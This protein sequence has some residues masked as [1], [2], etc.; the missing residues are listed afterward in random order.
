LLAFAVARGKLPDQMSNESLLFAPA[1]FPF[2]PIS[3]IRYREQVAPKRPVALAPAV[4]PT[5]LPEIPV[6]CR[7]EN[8]KQQYHVPLQLSAFTFSAYRGSEDRRGLPFSPGTRVRRTQIARSSARPSTRWPLDAGTP[9]R[10]TNMT[11]SLSRHGRNEAALAAVSQTNSL[12]DLPY[13]VLKGRPSR[14][15]LAHSL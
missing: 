11:A 10:C 1:N 12:Q 4:Q 3:D 8:A 9:K 6:V 7:A 14:N 15:L 2:R 5:F 13:L